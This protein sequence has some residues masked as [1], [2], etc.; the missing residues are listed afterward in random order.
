MDLSGGRDQNVGNT[1]MLADGE[2]PRGKSTSSAG[3]CQIQRQDAVF[4]IRDDCAYPG[5]Q[6]PGALMLFR[7]FQLSDAL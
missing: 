4:E 7:Q 2:R 3:D 6:G 1:W 5:L